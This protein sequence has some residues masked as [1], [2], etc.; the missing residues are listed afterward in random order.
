MTLDRRNFLLS[1]L[2]GLPLAGLGGSLR[3][4]GAGTSGDP[5]QVP[6]PFANRRMLTI[7][8]R[9]AN[10]AL[11]TVIPHA[12]PDY[13][14]M[15]GLR[16]ELRITQGQSL[17][18]NGYPSVG[19]HPSM[20]GL[21][22]LFNNQNSVALL[23]RI[24]NF[25]GERSHFTE[26][27]LLETGRTDYSATS[28]GW[29]P[30][31]LPDLVPHL[32]GNV[33]MPSVSVSNR[34][35][36][37]YLSGDQDEPTTHLQGAYGVD[38]ITDDRV[39]NIP[40][41][42]TSQG[43]DIADR[44]EL[45][46]PTGT[47]AYSVSDAGIY[48]RTSI[49]RAIDTLR[50]LRAPAYA[51]FTRQPLRYPSQ[52]GDQW[53]GNA[54]NGPQ[55]TFFSRLEESVFYLKTGLTRFAGIELGGWDTHNNQI[56]VGNSTTGTHADLLTI[57]SHA[58]KSAYDD[59]QFALGN[60]FVILVISEFGRTVAE[61]GSR[62]TDHGVGGAAIVAG[63]TVNGG[64]YNCWRPGWGGPQLG[65]EWRLLS[66]PDPNYADAIVPATDFRVPF[67]E[68]MDKFFGYG[69]LI[70][71]M[72]DIGPFWEQIRTTLSGQPRYA[73]LNFI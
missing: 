42:S 69:S 12:D 67:V 28:Q 71:N 39:L 48:Q 72:D 15:N 57:L 50:S 8:L 58:I 47:S 37:M 18:L 59:L 29:I 54:L 73:P 56:D 7:F 68:I 61:N 13:E 26:M 52:P 6:V 44:V 2:A 1:G 11:N 3:A 22:D 33:L 60:D 4:M 70:Q 35:Q 38:P 17:S 45:A 25:D 66:N 64:V 21:R 30:Q 31:V 55:R 49:A 63:P 62:G 14:G 27:L 40:F 34:M 5:T 36:R 19:L 65:Q 10:D 24:G 9:G 32:P 51:T 46:A 53:G 20:T 23:H 43:M 41:A 16:P